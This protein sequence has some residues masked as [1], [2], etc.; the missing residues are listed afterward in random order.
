MREKIK[1]HALLSSINAKRVCD[2]VKSIW[3]FGNQNCSE[4]LEEIPKKQLSDKMERLFE[5][6][7]STSCAAADEDKASTSDQ[8]SQASKSSIRIFTNAN[9]ETLILCCKDLIQDGK[10]LRQRMVDALQKTKRVQALLDTFKLEQLQAR[11]KYE[12]LKYAKKNK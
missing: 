8:T 10:I 7:E 12:R 3:K 1:G 6:D 9:V 2:K 5:K 11:L 4:I